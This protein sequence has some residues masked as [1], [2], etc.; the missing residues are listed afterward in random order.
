MRMFSILVAQLV[1][2]LAWAD[3]PAPAGWAHR[4]ADAR[5]IYTSLARQDIELR[6][7]PTALDQGPLRSWL[8]ARLARGIEGFSAVEFGDIQQNDGKTFMA[9]GTAGSARFVVALV[10][11]RSDGA[12]RY[13]ELILP[14]NPALIQ[15]H[16]RP[17]AQVL[18]QACLEK[19]DT[20]TVVSRTAAEKPDA[21][22]AA[23]ASPVAPLKRAA[24]VGTLRD[25]DIAGV[26]Y[27]WDQVYQVTGLQMLEWTYLLL[28]DGQAREGVPEEAIDA[29]DP[30]LDRRAHPEKWG[31]WKRNG[32]KL[33][34]DFGEG[35]AEPPNQMARAK[36]KRG[37]RL[38][39]HYR[40]SASANIGTT[41]SW[42]QWGL[43][44]NRDGTFRRWSSQGTGGTLL[45]TSALVVGDDKGS[46]SAVTAAGSFGGGG[47]KSTGVTDDDLE[48]E[49]YIDGWTL[50]LRYRSGKV[51]R[52]FFFRSPE[53]T[54]IWFEG[55]ELYVL[56]DD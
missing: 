51:Q 28:A 23:A 3:P 53:G 26:L 55:N 41:S 21:R 56:K 54:D 34:V 42:G 46:S 39:N 48:G 10:C 35:F 9:L 5:S 2:T 15:A 16:L 31:R 18:A 47:S 43:A 40:A 49:Y 13:A 44:L 12:K 30:A 14:Q 45:G 17:A 37:E 24:A 29:F 1:A 32:A 6:L 20:S 4:P 22:S 19:P 52:S 25:A 50:E 33:L 38:H 7:Y 36:G 8:E 11:A 27:A